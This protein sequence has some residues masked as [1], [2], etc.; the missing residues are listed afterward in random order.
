MRVR[1]EGHEEQRFCG[2][3]E[4]KRKL[5]GPRRRWENYVKMDLREIG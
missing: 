4:G 2:K 3:A 5:R 1:W